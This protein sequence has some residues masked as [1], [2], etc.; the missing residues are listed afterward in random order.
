MNNK[1]QFFIF[2]AVLVIFSLFVIQYS[3]L[4]SKQISQ[5]LED[6]PF[7]DIPFI[8]SY[9]ESSVRQTS[10]NSFENIYSTGDLTTVHR[11]FSNIYSAHYEIEEKELNYY[12]SELEVG[13][14]IVKASNIDFYHNIRYK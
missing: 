13:N 6:V 3:L 5:T 10:T 11:A 9:I 2:A 12:L 7:S 1:A 14:E 8:A 4:S